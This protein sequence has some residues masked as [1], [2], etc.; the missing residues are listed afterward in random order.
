[1]HYDK[2]RNK[3]ADKT[4]SIQWFSED[5]NSIR[6]KFYNNEKFYNISYSD[7]DILRNPKELKI[8]EKVYLNGHKLVN[9]TRILGFNSW[10]KVFYKNGFTRVVN[11]NQITSYK[12]LKSK[13]PNS[14]LRFNY[15][16]EL[17]TESAVYENDFLA[18]MYEG[19]D[20]IEGNNMLYKLLSKKRYS[21]NNTGL[22]NIFPFGLNLSQKKA[23][24]NAFDNDVSIIEGPPGTGKTQTILNIIANAVIRNKTVAVVSNNNAAIENVR[25]KLVE[26]NLDFLL[27]L[28]GNSENKSLFFNETVN[29]CKPI[30]F[31]E[32]SSSISLRVLSESLKMYQTELPKL[33]EAENTLAK[34]SEKVNSYK[35]EYIYFKRENAGNVIPDDLIRLKK[36]KE[37]NNALTVRAMLENKEKLNFFEK[38]VLRF[39]YGVKL[40]EVIEEVLPK[41]LV[42]LDELY[43]ELKISEITTS[44]NRLYKY[45][46]RGSFES[47][48][49][50][51]QEDSIDYLK[52]VLHKKYSSIQSV[53]YT[54]DNYR[55]LFDHFITEYPI[56]L[57]TSYA[58][59][60]SADRGFLF[61]YLIIDEAS[62]TDLLSSTLAMSCA[63]N[64]IVVGDT[65]QL[66]HIENKALI[67]VNEELK[68][69]YL[70]S[71]EY[72]YLTN[73]I[74]TSSM[75]VFSN[76]PRVMLKE[77]YRCH[78]DIINFCNKRYYDNELIILTNKDVS[79]E[80]LSIHK[81]VPGN[82]A[83]KNPNGSGMYNQ[84]EIDEII[85]LLEE[86]DKQPV[87]VITPY[88]YQADLLNEQLMSDNNTE[89]DTVHKFQGRAK[90]VII[91]STVVNDIQSRDLEDNSKSDFVSR[92][93]LLNVAVSRAKK[94]LKLVV[95]DKVFF[96]KNNAISDL[97]KYI[98]YNSPE[99]SIKHGKVHSIFDILYSDYSE[100]YKKFRKGKNKKEF[101]T[102]QLVDK[103]INEILDELNLDTLK[104]IPHYPLKH[105]ITNLEQLNEREINYSK[106]KWSHVDYAVLNTLTKEPVIVIEVDGISFHEQDAKQSERD[107]IKNKALNLNN[108]PILRLKTNESN[109]KSRIRDAII[110]AMR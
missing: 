12:D 108:I 35:K 42:K 56:V 45:L 11:E 50:S 33:Y 14:I 95:S 21:V 5:N 22:V 4:N 65:K 13:G 37:S 76:A 24:E 63:K 72:D 82:H 81:T 3:Y 97:V 43:Y 88:R 55:S 89:V 16:K 87:G 94:Q 7:M 103:L 41:L 85:V 59:I 109:E 30:D 1:M 64:M 75:K 101:A 58:L 29:K 100:E 25:D 36:I 60:P 57:S 51:Y 74:L 2:K 20:Y 91:L 18:S 66:P 110:N 104:A 31:L 49:K 9:H 38:I 27:A 68:Q 99:D 84:R 39:K 93:D 77:H 92:D 79:N 106:H 40:N 62:Q 70:V 34:L 71:N 26:Y 17:A 8:N 47:N 69:H 67:N 96:S 6:V 61:D 28:L 10:V 83:R 23:V 52:K 46:E 98:R 15:F 80:P 54:Y 107:S 105:L 102:E 44:I 86:I 48:K 78:P 53:E 90:D 32:K 19:L 73:N